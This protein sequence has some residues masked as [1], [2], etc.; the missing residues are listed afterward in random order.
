MAMQAPKGRTL[1]E[2]NCTLGEE[3]AR[4]VLWC[5]AELMGLSEHLCAHP[6]LFSMRSRTWSDP[7]GEWPLQT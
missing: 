3:G 7:P 5:A 6:Q 4:F 1:C 2:L